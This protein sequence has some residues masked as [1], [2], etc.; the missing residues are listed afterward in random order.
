MPELPRSETPADKAVRLL[1]VKRIAYACNLTTNAV[2]KWQTVGRG[3]IPSRHQPAVLQ[4]ARDLGAPFTADDVIGA[5][6][7][8]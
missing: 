8:A 1:G 2:W 7:A 5:R 6:A 4:L 3:R